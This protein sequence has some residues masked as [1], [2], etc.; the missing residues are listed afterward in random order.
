MDRLQKIIATSLCL[1]SFGL[2]Y[3]ILEN[4]TIEQNREVFGSVA[5]GCIVI[6]G[7]ALLFLITLIPD[8]LSI[9]YL[10]DEVKP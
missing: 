10:D 1:L 5:I 9:E 7:A 8:Y 4:A 6:G 3:T 2:T